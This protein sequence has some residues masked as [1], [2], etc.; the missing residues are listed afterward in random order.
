MM[1]QYKQMLPDLRIEVEFMELQYRRKFLDKKLTTRRE[2]AA[3]KRQNRAQLKAYKK[4][5]K[6]QQNDS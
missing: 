2:R 5:Q 6:E 1:D 3:V 4:Q